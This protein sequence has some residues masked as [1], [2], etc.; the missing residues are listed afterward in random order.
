MGTPSH[1][2][3]QCLLQP[4]Q[5][6][7]HFRFGV[8]FKLCI[9]RVHIF[10]FIQRVR[11]SLV[12]D[13]VADGIVAQFTLHG[14]I[15]VVDTVGTLHPHRFASEPFAQAL[16]MQVFDRPRAQAYIEQGVGTR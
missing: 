7:K 4:D 8:V 10:M 9:R 15:A 5:Y 16:Q 14:F 6:L 11:S 12:N 13:F 1:L 2:D 3:R